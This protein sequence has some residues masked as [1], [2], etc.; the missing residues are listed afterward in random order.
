[1]SMEKIR[2]YEIKAGRCISDEVDYVK[3]YYTHI[4]KTYGST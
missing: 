1:L 3:E 4:R 2:V